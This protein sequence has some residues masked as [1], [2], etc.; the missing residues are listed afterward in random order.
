[1]SEVLWTELEKMDV[2]RERMGI[3]Y[4]EARTALNMAQGD[5]IKA[6]DNLEKAQGLEEQEFN[7]ADRGHKIWESVR[8]KMGSFNNTTVSLKKHDNTIVTLSAPLGLA[9]AYTIWRKPGLRLIALA[10]AVGAAIN[11]FELEVASDDKSQY[12]DDAFNFKTDKEY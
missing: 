2:L 3:G 8:C 4:E 9:L 12:T 11:H 1:M 10:G 7:F 6:L 5:L